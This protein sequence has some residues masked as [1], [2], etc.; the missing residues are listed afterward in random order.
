MAVKRILKMVSIFDKVINHGGL[1]YFFVGH[2]EY[3]SM[4]SRDVIYNE[5]Y[6]LQR[7]ADYT[8]NLLHATVEVADGNCIRMDE[9][10]W[11]DN[12]TE[13]LEHGY[14]SAAKS[15]STTASPTTSM[16]PAEWSLSL[17]TKV[18]VSTILVVCCIGSCANAVVLT[19]LLRA[20]RQFGSCTHTLIA[21]QSAMDLSAS[22]T[23]MITSIVRFTYGY[24][25]NSGNRILDGAICM[26]FA[27]H[28]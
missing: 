22:V 2:P 18:T 1:G 25:Y 28:L 13:V 21:N 20:R 9:M 11:L 5:A 24:R 8:A 12:T 27:G 3:H 23:A 6:S 17:K 16:T 4:R 15:N 14:N 10:V 26:I 19:V 7:C